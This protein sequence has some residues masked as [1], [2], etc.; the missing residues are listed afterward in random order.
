MGEQARLTKVGDNEVHTITATKDPDLYI[1]NYVKETKEDTVWKIINHFCNGSPAERTLWRVC[2]HTCANIAQC[3][4]TLYEHYAARRV[5]DAEVSARRVEELLGQGDLSDSDR[6][7][8]AEIWY[9]SDL[10]TRG[11]DWW[12]FLQCLSGF[13]GEEFEKLRACE[14]FVSKYNRFIHEHDN[15]DLKTAISA[16]FKREAVMAALARI[17]FET[18]PKMMGQVGR[19]LVIA[20]K[21]G[22]SR[23][24]AIHG[25]KGKALENARLFHRCG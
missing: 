13:T 16:C 8:I 18:I 11:G 15:F 17:A 25:T 10:D 4:E 2:D 24:K 3:L 6:T 7:E 5:T 9:G 1:V 20:K 23:R 19:R 14:K 21:G 22:H 12:A